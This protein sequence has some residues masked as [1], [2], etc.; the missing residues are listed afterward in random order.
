MFLHKPQES[1]QQINSR[2]TDKSQR[3]LYSYIT[4]Q[5]L[6]ANGTH[7][8]AHKLLNCRK[9]L[10]EYPKQILT[11]ILDQIFTRIAF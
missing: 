8:V 9:C 11:V 6:N 4:G 7:F 2:R 10:H 1:S 5:K 3:Y